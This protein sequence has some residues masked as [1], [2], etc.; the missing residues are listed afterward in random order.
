MKRRPPIARIISQL[1]FFVVFIVLIRMKRPMNW[2]IVFV[3]SALLSAVFSRFYCGWT[4]PINTAM[5]VS[6]WIGRKLRIQNRQVPKA[7]RS[8]AFGYVML[9]LT[10]VLAFLN[11]THRVKLP[12]LLIMTAAGFLVTL[13]Y[14]Q[15]VW[16]NYLCPY[17]LLL[18]LPSRFAR[19]GMNVGSACVPSCDK[20]ARVCPAEAVEIDSRGAEIDPSLCLVC[21]KCSVVCPTHAIAYGR[22]PH[23]ESPAP[24]ARSVVGA[25]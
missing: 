1:L 14:T 7:L 8:G 10:L 16:H 19:F 21:R 17:G 2:M 24:P 5:Q 11:V 13:R 3:V 23:D 22:T 18:R 4:C 15:S 25:K 9:G 6:E 12:F 20:C